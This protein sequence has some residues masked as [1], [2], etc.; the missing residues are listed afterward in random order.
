MPGPNSKVDPWRRRTIGSPTMRQPVADL[1]S[2]ATSFLAARRPESLDQKIVGSITQLESIIADLRQRFAQGEQLDLTKLAAQISTLEGLNGAHDAGL[3]LVFWKGRQWQCSELIGDNLQSANKWHQVFMV[4]NKLQTAI[5]S[6]TDSLALESEINDNLTGVVEFE[7]ELAM[8]ESLIAEWRTEKSAS[9]LGYRAVDPQRIF[10]RWRLNQDLPEPKRVQIVT[11]I[12]EI[13]RDDRVG[14]A[15]LIA[16]QTN[17]ITKIKSPRE[18]GNLVAAVAEYKAKSG[19][20]SDQLV[21][22][23]LELVQLTRYEL[24]LRSGGDSDIEKAESEEIN[25]QLRMLEP[26]ATDFESDSD[27]RDQ[28]EGPA[29]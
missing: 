4:L 6:D 26:D 29:Q 8:C 27:C 11:E 20:K 25:K 2:R 23:T 28:A 17:N 1:L 22:R 19:E 18:N 13:V 12:I 9:S 3:K 5:A 14:L 16:L 24:T 21:R 15:Q 10:L 7:Q